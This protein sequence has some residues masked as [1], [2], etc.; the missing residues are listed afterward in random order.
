MDSI[1][2]PAPPTVPPSPLLT[3]WPRPAQAA[4]A[5]LLLLAT[6][7]LGVQAFLSWGASRPTELHAG[8]APPYRIDLNAADRVELLQLP[9]VGPGLA[10]RIEDY[11]TEHGGFRRVD[12]LA[13]V[14]GVGPATLERLR[15]WV[16]VREGGAGEVRPAPP[17][18]AKASGKAAKHTGP[19]D[20]NRA[21]AEELQQL[22]RIGP[23]LAQRILEARAQQPF[24]SVEELR[25]VSGIGA[26]TLEQLRPYVTVDREAGRVVKAD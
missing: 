11:R 12:D 3:A 16:R 22:P 25:R 8:A 19:V 5:V 26:K 20:L 15:P 21:T 2:P 6:V 13:A 1:A 7:L 9:D 17:P 24:H 10:Q 14:H 4:A 18:T 23:K